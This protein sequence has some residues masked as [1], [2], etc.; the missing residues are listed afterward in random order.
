MAFRYDSLLFRAAVGLGVLLPLAACTPGGQFDPTE[1]FSSDVFDSKTKLKGDRVPLF[2]N[3]VPGATT[4][5]PADLVK[6]YQ[7]PPEPPETDAAATPAAEPAKTQPKPKPKPKP[8]IA[9]EK[10]PASTPTRIDIGAKTGTSAQQAQPATAWP[11]APQTAASQQ[12]GQFARPA[13]PSTA[14]AQAGGAS[15]SVWPAP[16]STAG[17]QQAATPSQSIWPNPPAAGTSSQ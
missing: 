13:S 1:L 11:A 15:Q 3:G 17:A 5:V 9:A 14:P 12:A 4:G 8:K 6:G 2:P 10:R 16:P 7:P